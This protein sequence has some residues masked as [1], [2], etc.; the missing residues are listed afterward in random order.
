MRT[1]KLDEL[2]PFFPLEKKTALGFF[3]MLE[4]EPFHTP[5]IWMDNC[6]G[7]AGL[8]KPLASFSGL[9]MSATLGF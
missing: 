6:Q 4:T 5:Y 2:G 9:G 3:H 1:L 7:R 8:D